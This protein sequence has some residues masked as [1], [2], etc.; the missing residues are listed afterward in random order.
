[1]DATDRRAIKNTGAKT[2]W[3]HLSRGEQE[4]LLRKM[5]LK[6]ARFLGGTAPSDLAVVD[7]WEQLPEAV[8]EELLKAYDLATQ[9]FDLALYKK[10]TKRQKL[11]VHGRPFAR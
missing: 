3:E 10:N 4:D 5:S 1:M 7:T 2:A 6:G 11:D 8:Q 9:Q